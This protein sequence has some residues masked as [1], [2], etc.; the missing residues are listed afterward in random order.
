LIKIRIFE[1]PCESTG[2]YRIYSQH[3]S[4]IRLLRVSKSGEF[5][6]SSSSIDK[7]IFIWRIISDKAR[8]NQAEMSE[9]QMMDSD[10]EL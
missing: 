9:T 5:L 7:C 1:Y 2:Y 4:F 10:A 6:L 3:L 8:G